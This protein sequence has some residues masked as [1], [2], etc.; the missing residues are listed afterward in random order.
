[1]TV[2]YSPLAGREHFLVCEICD[3]HLARFWEADLRRPLHGGMFRP[4]DQG[5]SLPWPHPADVITWEALRC[6]YCKHR[7][8]VRDDTVMTSRGPYMIPIEEAELEITLAKISD[9]AKALLD[10]WDEIGGLPEISEAVG[11]ESGPAVGEGSEGSE[12]PATPP[13]PP[14]RA[15]TQRAKPAAPKVSKPKAKAKGKA[16]A[17]SGSKRP[18]AGSGGVSS[19][20]SKRK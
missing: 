18:G 12:K 3:E 14:Q 11:Q 16:K 10:E 7:P 6:P 2:S 19:G 4:L 20:T 13:T 17:G 15:V 8:M 1:M 5:Y 9:R